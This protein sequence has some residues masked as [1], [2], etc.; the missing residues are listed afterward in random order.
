MALTTPVLSKS[1]SEGNTPGQSKYIYRRT[2]PLSANI[3]GPKRFV[4]V[5]FEKTSERLLANIVDVEKQVKTSLKKSMS[6]LELNSIQQTGSYV[7]PLATPHGI[8]RKRGKRKK[9]KT[10][11]AKQ[12]GAGRDTLDSPSALDTYVRPHTSHGVPTSN[13]HSSFQKHAANNRNPNGPLSP[14]E[15]IYTEEQRCKQ[16][17]PQL[18]SSD[19][20]NLKKSKPLSPASSP[21]PSLQMLEQFTRSLSES[22]NSTVKVQDLSNLDELIQ[23][24]DILISKHA[25]E[26]DEFKSSFKRL[27][28]RKPNDKTKEPW[29]RTKLK[30][31]KSSEKAIASILQRHG[32]NIYEAAKSIST[33]PEQVVTRWVKVEH[34]LMVLELR[35]KE[36][37]AAQFQKRKIKEYKQ[38]KRRQR[39]EVKAFLVRAVSLRNLNTDSPQTYVGESVVTGSLLS[40]EQAAG[41]ETLQNAHSRPG[42]RIDLNTKKYTMEREKHGKKSRKRGTFFGTYK[43]NQADALKREQKHVTK[44]VVEQEK[45]V[46]KEEYESDDFEADDEITEIVPVPELKLGVT[47]SHIQVV[48]QQV[49]AGVDADRSMAMDNSIHEKKYT[50]ARQKHGKRSRKRGTFFGMYDQKKANMVKAGVD[51][52]AHQRKLVAI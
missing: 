37:L 26:R 3:R 34:E 6:N 20:G 22:T 29:S 21:S 13:M 41:H 16:W 31:L 39:D 50:L 45:Y 46:E 12:S 35:E 49:S 48:R 17:E 7:T 24:L 19:S 15:K 30:D 32:G 38:L 40:N 44:R 33:N 5:L 27:T 14:I 18:K 11:N 52:N 1:R 8:G 51:S 9:K 10:G 23:S 36:E 47:K 43:Q 4:P 28:R 2:R 42:N 25:T